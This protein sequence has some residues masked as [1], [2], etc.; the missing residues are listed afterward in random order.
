[1]AALANHVE[2]ESSH[3]YTFRKGS[4]TTVEGERAW[5]RD[6]HTL[7]EVANQDFVRLTIEGHAAMYKELGYIVELKWSDDRNDADLAVEH[8]R[9]AKVDYDNVAVLEGSMAAT[10]LKAAWGGPG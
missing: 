1:M 3:S 7:P 6:I 2:A 9:G 10:K 4:E 5:W 8:R